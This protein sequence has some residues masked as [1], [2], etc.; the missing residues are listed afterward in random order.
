[1]P[2]GLCNGRKKNALRTRLGSEDR[3]RPGF[4][5]TWLHS[6]DC[7]NFLVGVVCILRGTCFILKKLVAILRFG[8][9][10]LSRV[11]IL[12]APG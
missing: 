10:P 12:S 9:T 3:V 2:C 11:L 1:M 6:I 8:L 5:G 7:G 4:E